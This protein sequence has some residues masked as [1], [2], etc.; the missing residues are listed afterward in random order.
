MPLVVI[1]QSLKMKVHLCIWRTCTLMVHENML[2]D[3]LEIFSCLLMID[4][5]VAY[6]PFIQ[7]CKKD[8]PP[9]LT[10]IRASEAS[11]T[12]HMGLRASALPAATR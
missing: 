6:A 4:S 1:R 8:L 9:P 5:F 7:K 2:C 10:S 11:K 12:V 3:L